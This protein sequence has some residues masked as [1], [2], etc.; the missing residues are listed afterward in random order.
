MISAY[1][2][3][4]IDGGMVR[5]PDDAMVD[6][7]T[8]DWIIENEGTPPDISVELEPYLWRQGRDSQLEAAIE[9]VKKELETY[10]P[11]SDARPPYPDRSKLPMRKN[12]KANEKQPEFWKKIG[13]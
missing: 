1:G 7:Q 3:S 4:V 9:V 10:K 5:A 11:T 2:F 6:I 8:G 12:K 13:G